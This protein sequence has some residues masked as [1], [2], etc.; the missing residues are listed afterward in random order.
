[1]IY[2]IIDWDLRYENNRSRAYKKLDWVPMPNKMDGDGYTELVETKNG[3]PEIN[4]ALRFAGWC[5]LIQIASRCRPRGLLCRDLAG[6]R[7]HTA[8]TLSRISR[9]PKM[10]FD[11]V[12]ERALEIGWIEVINNENKQ[13][14]GSAEILQSVALNRIEENRIEEKGKESGA[15][16]ENFNFENYKNM[17]TIPER[18][19]NESWFMPAWEKRIE[20]LYNHDQKCPRRETKLDANFLE[21]S[22]RLMLSSADPKKL[23]EFH[24]D[25]HWIHLDEERMNKSNG[26]QQVKQTIQKRN[27]EDR[28]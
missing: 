11:L 6:D 19:R 5:A 20:I 28:K 17:V 22:L 27:Y 2:R 4:G 15:L 26:Q 1:M 13:L 10:V 16:L 9:L 8:E 25:R 24:N 14:H 12:F 7:P 3:E 18:F 21:T 23:I